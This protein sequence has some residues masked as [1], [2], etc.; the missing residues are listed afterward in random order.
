MPTGFE[1]F[2]K[3]ALQ[4]EP[5][6][7]GRKAVE[8]KVAET[9]AKP[10]PAKVEPTRPQVERPVVERPVVQR[11]SR[12]VEPETKRRGRPKKEDRDSEGLAT[13]TIQMHPEAKDKL[14]EMKFREHKNMW[15]LVEEALDDLYCK[16]YGK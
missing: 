2:S 12:V 7:I 3:R 6:T 5:I 9:S 10:E 14:M 11:A 13:V 8:E 16:Y 1:K 15:E 4:E